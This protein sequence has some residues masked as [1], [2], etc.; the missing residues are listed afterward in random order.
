M[1]RWSRGNQACKAN[2]ELES[3][4]PGGGDDIRG[5]TR[6]FDVRDL[7]EATLELNGRGKRDGGEEE[8]AEDSLE[9]HV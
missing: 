9:L 8:G 7:G 5:T 1:R 3:S 6:A 2:L 4:K